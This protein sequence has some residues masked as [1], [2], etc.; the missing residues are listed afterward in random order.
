[1]G[2]RDSVNDKK[3]ERHDL[4]RIEKKLNDHTRMLLK[5]VNAGESHGHLDRITKSKI[6]NSETV[7][8]KYFLFKER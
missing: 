3:L 5:V 7:A 2:L 8:P 4:R 6:T 1:M